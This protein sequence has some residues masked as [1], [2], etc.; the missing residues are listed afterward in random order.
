MTTLT[1]D[2]PEDPNCN[3]W[4]LHPDSSNVWITVGG[5]SVYIRRLEEGAMTVELFGEGKEGHNPLDFCYGEPE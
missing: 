1:P 3:D 5:I 4:T 2:H